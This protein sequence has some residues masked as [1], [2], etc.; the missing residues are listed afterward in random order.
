MR[1]LAFLLGA[2][3][4][5]VAAVYFLMPADSLPSFLPGYEAGLMRP[6]YKHGVAA[7]VVGASSA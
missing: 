5:V 7:G 1:S 4:I 2:I 6:R 3:L